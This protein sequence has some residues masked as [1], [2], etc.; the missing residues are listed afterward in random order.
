MSLTNSTIS[1]IAS[2]GLSLNISHSNLHY[3]VGVVGS[4]GVRRIYNMGSIIDKYRD[5]ILQDMVDIELDDL[6][7][8]KYRYKPRSFCDDVFN[9]KELWSALLRLNNMLT[10]I[11]FDKKKIKV[12]GPNFTKLLDEILTIE[13]DAIIAS[14]ISAKTE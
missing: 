12:F 5:I 1:S 6:E 13:D 9:D 2:K 14:V 4:D 3:K 11:D 8:E 10:A 7:L